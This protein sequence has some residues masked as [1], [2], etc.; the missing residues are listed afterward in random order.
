MKESRFKERPGSRF[1]R[2]AEPLNEA[3]TKSGEALASTDDPGLDG[4]EPI[5]EQPLDDAVDDLDDLAVTDVV[6]EGFRSMSEAPDDARPVLLTDGSPAS[7][8]QHALNGVRVVEAV[9]R[10]T[11]RY[12]LPARCW[13]VSRFWAVR[14]SGGQRIDFEPIGWSPL[15]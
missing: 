5:Q 6:P 13:R 4:V 11:R 15:S 14:N 2:P 9:S 12:D 10:E 1:Q 7:E 8:G 3:L